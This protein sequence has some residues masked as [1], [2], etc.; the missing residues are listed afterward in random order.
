MNRSVLLVLPVIAVLLTSGCTDLSGIP[1]IGPALGGL[2]GPSTVKYTNDVVII[3]SFEATPN[4]VF[5]GQQVRLVAYVQNQGKNTLKDVRVELY[6]FCQ[7]TFTLD[8]TDCGTGSDSKEAYCDKITLSPYETKE[9]RWTLTADKC[10]KLE[11][12]CP[13]DGMKVSVKYKQKTEGMSTISLIKYEEMQRQMNEGTYK[14]T[15][16]TRAAGEGPI[17]GYITVEDK[18][19]V[20]VSGSKSQTVISFQ[21][22]NEGS[23]FLAFKPDFTHTSGTVQKPKVDFSGIKGL[24]DWASITSS[25][26][27]DNCNSL[28]NGA[29]D[30]KGIELKI[31]R[32]HV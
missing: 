24:T 14:E 1:L 10:I 27:D 26:T 5:P 2:F 8:N 15:Q 3:R 31:G 21:L 12:T 23:G 6:D 32:A 7:G 9:V 17:K 16:S 11:T 20:A 28:A 19:P 25:S 22:K 30:D 29:T 13:S 18:Q 4:T